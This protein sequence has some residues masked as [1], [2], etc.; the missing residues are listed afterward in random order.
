MK[1]M[2]K[3]ATI[4]AG[5]IL[6]FVQS[7]QLQC[8]PHVTLHHNVWHHLMTL[9]LW[10]NSHLPEHTN[11]NMHKNISVIHFILIFDILFQT[12]VTGGFIE[13]S[14]YKVL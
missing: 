6:V 8:L 5:L 9:M 12:K 7:S 4:L 13:I 3:A 11:I 1:S 14:N 10:Q 2:V